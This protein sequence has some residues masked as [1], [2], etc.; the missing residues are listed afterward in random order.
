MKAEKDPGWAQTEPQIPLYEIYQA[1]RRTFGHQHWWPA[2]TAEEVIIGAV[3]A[4]NVAWKNASRAI[5][6]LKE[7][8][9]LSLADLHETD[10]AVIAPLIRPSRFYNQKAQRLKNLSDL[11]MDR[12]QGSLEAMLAADLSLLK[13]EL[14]NLSGFGNETVDS[15]LLYAAQKPVF[16]IDAYTRRIFSRLGLISPDWSYRACQQYFMDRLPADLDLYQDFHAQIVCLGS[17]ICKKKNSLC[18]YSPL[19]RWCEKK[20]RAIA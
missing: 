17:Q 12:F 15:I 7:K 4:Q 16:V 8:Q 19:M 10:A 20:M 5:Q 18:S 6:A 3:L 14:M 2:E 1:L 13:K 9:L 11:L